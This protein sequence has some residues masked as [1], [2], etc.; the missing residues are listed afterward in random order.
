MYAPHGVQFFADIHA[1][2]AAT[3]EHIIG[4]AQECKDFFE[5]LSIKSDDSTV[6]ADSGVSSDGVLAV[7]ELATDRF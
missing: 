2:V 4:R 3:T 6:L 5:D 7:I 1:A